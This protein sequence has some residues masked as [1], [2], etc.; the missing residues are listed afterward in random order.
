MN[1]FE[2]LIPELDG[3]LTPDSFKIFNQLFQ[4]VLDREIAIF[5]GA[6][7][8][9]ET[10]IPTWGEFLKELV[11]RLQDFSLPIDEISEP[12]FAS[13]LKSKYESEG[14]N[15][16]EVIKQ[17]IT[18]RKLPHLSSH[19][20]LLSDDILFCVTTNFD[21]VFDVAMELNDI[22]NVTPQYYPTFRITKILTD[23]LCYLHGNVFHDTNIIFTQESYNE[24]YINGGYIDRFMKAIYKENSL[25]FIG[26]SFQDK[27]LR[28]IIE[29][30]EL[31]QDRMWGRAGPHYIF[32]PLSRRGTDGEKF[33]YKNLIKSINLSPIF[34]YKNG[35]TDDLYYNL[36]YIIEFLFKS[37]NIARF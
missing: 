6:G 13:I 8:S 4:Q 27:A 17:I 25:L 19:V 2:Y 33:K 7:M 15:F 10:G 30:F 1:D 36:H 11:N 35:D 5:V 16:F 37:V 23:K 12:E 28:K 14:K 21:N 3:K 22:D 34:Y 20:K 9:Y 18:N 26:V 29:D 32:F 24:A 31:H